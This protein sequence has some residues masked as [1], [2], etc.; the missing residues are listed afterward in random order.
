MVCLYTYNRYRYG[1]RIPIHSLTAVLALVYGAISP[2]VP[3]AGML[4]M[5]TAMVET[6]YGVGY[7]TTPAFQTGGLMWPVFVSHIYAGNPV[8]D[9][10]P[11]PVTQ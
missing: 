10:L 2:V 11:H 8:T 4:Y 1:Y 3:L 5:A 7:Q 6:K 9:T